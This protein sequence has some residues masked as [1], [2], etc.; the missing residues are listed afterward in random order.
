ME[1]EGPVLLESGE[2]DGMPPQ[3]KPH[4][5][6]RFDHDPSAF[7]Q[8]F[9]YFKG[10]ILET[11]GM[12]K[13]SHLQTIDIKTG[14]VNRLAT[15]GPK[16]FGEGVTVHNDMI[17]YLTWRSQKAF[18][19]SASTFE[20]LGEFVFPEEIKQGWGLCSDGDHL[21][22][23]DGTSKIHFLE[24]T[25]TLATADNQHSD[26]QKAT[27]DSKPAKY[28]FAVELERSVTVTL[29]DDQG[30]HEIPMINELE[31]VNGFI[32]A[33]VWHQDVIAVISPQDGRIVQVIDCSGLYPP[34]LN[35]RKSDREA[36]LNGIAVLR[37]DNGTPL[38]PKFF[39]TGKLWPDVFEV[40]FPPPPSAD[41]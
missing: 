4:V 30:S 29:S 39:I 25:A 24:A 22:M 6:G 17:W 27:E 2:A 28:K 15:L 32:Y 18:V 31:Y 36:V 40:I 26:E 8:G 23:S 1:G 12:Y 14:E 19:F 13:Q 10:K 35:P 37:D 34:D 5:V 41:K 20:L 16:Y 7:T 9:Q 11:T 33:N 3:W 38:P 21:I